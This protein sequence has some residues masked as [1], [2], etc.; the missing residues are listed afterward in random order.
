VKWE[1]TLTY[2]KIEALLKAGGYQISALREVHAGGRNRSGRLSEVVLLTDKGKF[3]LSAVKFRKAIGYGVIKS[4]NFDVV[5]G[6]DGVRFNGTGYGHGVGLCQWGAKHRA[7]D[8]F[9]YREIL[10]YYYPGT[11]VERYSHE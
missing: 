4:T 10:S 1:L 7:G 9:D 8:G 2:R 3:S 6:D 11:Q 5:N